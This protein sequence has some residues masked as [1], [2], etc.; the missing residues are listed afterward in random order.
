MVS[1]LHPK[2]IAIVAHR[3]LSTSFKG[4]I[5][6]WKRWSCWE[7]LNF[8]ALPPEHRARLLQCLVTTLESEYEGNF[9]AIV[10]R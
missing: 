5:W 8:R 7:D 3:S 10:A 1:K 9:G 2:Y 4:L 6:I